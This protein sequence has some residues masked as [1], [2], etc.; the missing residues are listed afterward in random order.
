MG[1]WGWE[2]QDWKT[3]VWH[4]VCELLQYYEK[5]TNQ[6]QDGHFLRFSETTIT[7]APPCSVTRPFSECLVCWRLLHDC[8]ERSSQDTLSS[9]GWWVWCFM[10]TKFGWCDILGEHL[11]HIEAWLCKTTQWKYDVKLRHIHIAA[12]FGCQFTFYSLIAFC[13]YIIH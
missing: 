1:T 10:S 3:R 4:I 12:K 11:F 13:T 7:E 2:T 6:T 5:F 8:H 9:I